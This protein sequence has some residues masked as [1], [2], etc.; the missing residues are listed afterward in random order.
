MHLLAPLGIPD[1]A[2][3]CVFFDQFCCFE[4]TVLLS[5][6]CWFIYTY[7]SNHVFKNTLEKGLGHKQK[8]N[9]KYWLKFLNVLLENSFSV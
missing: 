1:S 5:S 4:Q 9:V 7:L 8:V 2:D 6:Y 3:N